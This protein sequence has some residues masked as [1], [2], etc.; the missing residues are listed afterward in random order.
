MSPVTTRRSGWLSSP[1]R[2]PCPASVAGTT[3]TYSN[4]ADAVRATNRQGGRPAVYVQWGKHGSLLEGWTEMHVAGISV[5]EDMRR[6]YERLRTEGRRLAD[7]PPARHWPVR[8]SGKWDD[9]VDFSCPVD[10]LDWLRRTHK[11]IVSRWANA[12]INQHFLLV[13]FHPKW[14]WPAEA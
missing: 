6:T 10:P 9:F 13:N 5:R 1:A 14:E 8:F 4:S 7:F 3:A 2:R 12:A 11:V